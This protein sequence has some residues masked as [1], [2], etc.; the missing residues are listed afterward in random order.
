MHWRTVLWI[1]CRSLAG[2]G[3][4]LAD[5]VQVAES[6]WQKLAS[7]YIK[8]G[9]ESVAFISSLWGSGGVRRFHSLLQMHFDLSVE[10]NL[11][12]CKVL[13]CVFRMHPVLMLMY[14]T[15]I[16]FCKYISHAGRRHVLLQKYDMLYLLIHG[17]TRSYTV[18]HGPT[19]SYTAL[20]DPTRS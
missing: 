20:H 9:C 18:L 5:L 14:S 16:R 19:R 13:R 10:C 12:G 11:L 7:H 17:L 2:L 3:T 1:L 15:M 4:G 6:F 8:T